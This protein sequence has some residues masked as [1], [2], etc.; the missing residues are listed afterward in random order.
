VTFGGHVDD[1][2]ATWRRHHVLLLASRAEGTPLSLLEAMALARPSVVTDV[3]G[4]AEWV[5]P[6]ETGFLAAAPTA[7][8]FGAALEACWHAR[9]QWEAMGSRAH[10]VL[11]QNY[12]PT[13]G[14][15]LLHRVEE[16][17]RQ[18]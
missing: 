9:D 2:V 11:L 7:V 18:R 5:V 10:Q 14:R 4:N 16:A 6:D 13:P 12:D 15:T 17:G 3:G 1:I 8:S